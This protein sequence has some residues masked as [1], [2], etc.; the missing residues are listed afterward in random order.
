MTV[1]W[2]HWWV[3]RSF[4]DTEFQISEQ[5]T[6]LSILIRRR[7]YRTQGWAS[8]HGFPHPKE[9]LSL[10]TLYLF[11][12]RFLS[13]KW[14]AWACMFLCDSWEKQGWGIGPE[15]KRVTLDGNSFY[16]F[17]KHTFTRFLLSASSCGTYILVGNAIK[18]NRRNKKIIEIISREWQMLW[19]K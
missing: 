4:E 17:I 19:K 5:P 9:N 11:K 6:R 7:V 13:E 12:F 2:D 3:S 16:S 8:D 14:M 1:A 15:L 10:F 18:E